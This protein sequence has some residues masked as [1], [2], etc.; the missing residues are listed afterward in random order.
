MPHIM[1]SC[2]NNHAQNLHVTELPAEVVM[3]QNA[4]ERLGDVSRMCTVVVWVALIRLFNILQGAK[5]SHHAWGLL[6]ALTGR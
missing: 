2:C 4:A 5:G 1:H 6:W 3:S